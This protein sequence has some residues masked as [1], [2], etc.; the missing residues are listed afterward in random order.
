[1]PGVTALMASY[2][3]AA[4]PAAGPDITGS[5][6]IGNG[7]GGLY[8][9]S[10]GAPQQFISPWGSLTQDP[11]GIIFSI[12]YSPTYEETVMGFVIGTYTGAN[13]ELVV[14]DR[15]TINS[16]TT[17]TVKIGAVTQTMSATPEEDTRVIIYGADPF[18][19][20]A[21][22]GQTVAVEITVG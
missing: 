16:I 1:M 14:S 5:M 3:G 2:G 8:G 13:G 21:Q 4:G 11:S 20:V 6:T 22:D 9:Y 15:E 18:N 10:P 19:L 12:N 17:F 7:F